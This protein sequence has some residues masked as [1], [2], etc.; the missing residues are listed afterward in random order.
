MSLLKFLFLICFT[1]TVLA[2]DNSGYIDFGH[3]S[4][5]PDPPARQ[6]GELEGKP[7]QQADDAYIEN[8]NGENVPV[9]TEQQPGPAETS[10]AYIESPAS[11]LPQEMVQQTGEVKR[12]YFTSGIEN[13]EPVDNL[14]SL[15]NDH[16]SVYFYT[17]LRNFEGQTIT[18]R[19]EYNN[20]VLA[21]VSFNVQ[22]PRWRVWSKKTL[23]PDW[24]GDIHVNVVDE[25][26][27]ILAAGVLTFTES[28]QP[29][30]F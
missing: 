2:A 13:H 20:Q 19:W 5:L 30:T 7:A 21:E 16:G 6:A 8:P 27:R 3:S 18:H 28:S 9:Y 24:I 29:P 4:E 22:G 1:S 23:L 15:S 12:S 26:D 25:Q 10:D 11:D 14:L 17:D